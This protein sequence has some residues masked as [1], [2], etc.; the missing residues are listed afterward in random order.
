MRNNAAHAW[1]PKRKKSMTTLDYH[2]VLSSL[3]R[4]AE[5]ARVKNVYANKGIYELRLASNEISIYL[6]PP[7]GLFPYKG[8]LTTYVQESPLLKEIRSVAKSRIITAMYQL[9]F[10]RVIAIEFGDDALIYEGVREGNIVIASSKTIVA[11][12]NERKM[13]D[14]ST[15]R[16]AAYI[17]PPPPKIDMFSLTLK[18]LL[19]LTESARQSRPIIVRLIRELS[20]PAEIASEALYRSGIDLNY[21]ETLGEDECIKLLRNIQGIIKESFENKGCY[22]AILG[23]EVFGIYPFKP[24]LLE[25]LGAKIVNEENFS[26]TLGEYFIRLFEEGL[27]EEED[28]IASQIKAT[29]ESYLNEASDL[30]RIGATLLSNIDYLE[31][32]RMKAIELRSSGA[33]AEE[34]AEALSGEYPIIGVDEL[35]K[36]VTVKIED[37]IFK[38][39][40]EESIGKQASEIFSRAKKLEEKAE[41]AREVMKKRLEQGKK[42]RPK[43]VFKAVKKRAW[44]TSFRYF[45]SSEG[46]LVVGGKDASQNEALVRKYLSPQ[47]IFLHADI[48]G[49]PVVIIKTEGKT[50]GEKTIRE[51]AQLAAAFSRAWEAGFASI[52]VY[53][54]YG[55]QVSKK[56]P[57]GEYLSRGAFMVYGKRNYLRNTPL[58]WSIGLKTE[59]DRCELICAPPSVVSERCDFWAILMPGRLRR[60]FIVRKLVKYFKES[61]EKMGI[62]VKLVAEEILICLPKGGIYISRWGK[63]V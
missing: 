4:D 44:Y 22:K 12:I 37:Q 25:S 60:E 14:R 23:N 1:T 62:R 54:V 45:F 11:A 30:R 36:E 47:D 51:A 27:K 18:D 57:S 41:K 20:I 5:G 15:T 19:K 43:K 9:N 24:R 58:E 7:Y 32:L 35:R 28:K 33:S 42:E 52:D 53:W 34:I 3:W 17:P 50:P 55:S 26:L 2:L 40:M 56:A 63:R 48:H 16:G 10:D 31:N 39:K 59:E 29:I 49:G 13:R 21:A 8:R 61:A 38:I 46:F 6:W